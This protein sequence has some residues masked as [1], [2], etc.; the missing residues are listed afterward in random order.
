QSFIDSAVYVGATFDDIRAIY[1]S[2]PIGDKYREQRRSGDKYLSRSFERAQAWL[3]RRGAG[4][5]E[6]VDPITRLMSESA[7]AFDR[8]WELL[9]ELALV[10]PLTLAQLL[11]RV[12]W[13]KGDTVAGH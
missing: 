5:R 7:L 8:L 6:A 13:R 1:A 4:P 11:R 10:A 9:W 2:C 3:T 12:R